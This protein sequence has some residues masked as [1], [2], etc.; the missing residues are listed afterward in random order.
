MFAG[1][2]HTLKIKSDRVGMH[3]SNVFVIECKGRCAT[4]W[5]AAALN[6]VAGVVCWHGWFRP[7]E[8]AIEAGAADVDAVVDG[9]LR[10]ARSGEHR[11]VGNIHGSIKDPEIIERLEAEGISVTRLGLVR[12][13]AERIVSFTEKWNRNARDPEIANIYVRQAQRLERPMALAR[14]ILK[15]EP[16]LPELNF[17]RACETVPWHDIYLMQS[18]VRVFRYEDVTSD[19]ANLEELAALALSGDRERAQQTATAAAS[20]APIDR[21]EAQS[22]GPSD[23]WTKLLPWQR[24]FFIAHH[25]HLRD[26]FVRYYAS[27]NRAGLSYD[28]SFMFEPFLER[29]EDAWDPERGAMRTAG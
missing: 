20:V 18:G 8:K 12:H 28:V 1:N 10:D 23:R 26:H 19:L 13:P 17:I 15:R 3:Q 21:T 4:Q 29:V 2:L 14:E 9:I 6:Q 27:V 16:D 7:G 22:L 5:I 25:G 24:A 11:H